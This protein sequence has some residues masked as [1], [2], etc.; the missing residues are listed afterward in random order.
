MVERKLETDRLVESLVGSR[1]H[2]SGRIRVGPVEPFLENFKD[3]VGEEDGFNGL[4]ATFD[5]LHPDPKRND[6]ESRHCRDLDASTVHRS[7][8]KEIDDGVHLLAQHHRKIRGLGVTFQDDGV[9]Y[10]LVKPATLETVTYYENACGRNSGCNCN[11]VSSGI[12]LEIV[13][14]VHFFFFCKLVLH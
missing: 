8:A 2:D 9:V 1:A 6:I 10:L 11:S 5:V 13:L 4:S 12:V 3:F 7:L 14:V